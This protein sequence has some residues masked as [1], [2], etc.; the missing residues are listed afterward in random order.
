[1]KERMAKALY[2]HWAA[3]D[4]ANEYC[5]W[6]Q[7]GDKATW[8]SRAEA[9]LKS[10]FGPTHQMIHAGEAWRGHCSDTDSLWNEMLQAALHPDSYPATPHPLYA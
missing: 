4:F 10:M 9:G 8:L 2:E 1:M 7:L 6:E 5:S 3:E